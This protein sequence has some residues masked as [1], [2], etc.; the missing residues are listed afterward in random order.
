MFCILL[1]LFVHESNYIF[2]C[3]FDILSEEVTALLEII[4]FFSSGGTRWR[5]RL[6]HCGTSRNVAGSI[7]VGVTGIFHLHNP[8]GRIIALGLTQ[9]LTELST[10]NIS[11]GVKAAGA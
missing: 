2:I 10:R 7:P 3:S 11:L 6:R 5:S 9:P 8:S 1:Q 4:L